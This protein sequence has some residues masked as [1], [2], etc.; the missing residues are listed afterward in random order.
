MSSKPTA[1][2]AGHEPVFREFEHTGDVGIELTAPTRDELFRRAAIALASLLVETSSVEQAEQREV[3]IAAGTDS[4]LM[5]DLLTELLCLFTVE[6]FVWSDASVKEADGSLCVTLRG[7]RFDPARHQFRG[8][9]KAVTYH[10]L[11]VANS[12]DGWR[13]RIIFDV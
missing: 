12:P 4:D 2:A 13:A 7:E 5:H 1:K 8:E 3:A 11:T 9:I 6:G 10:Q